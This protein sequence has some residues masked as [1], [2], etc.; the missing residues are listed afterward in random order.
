M[1]QKHTK[2]LLTPF[3]LGGITLPNRIIM[4]SMTRA[5]ATNTAI[6]PTDLHVAYY[7]QRASAGLIL[8]ESVWVSKNAIGFLNIPGIF[9]SAQTE[10]WKKVTDA[11]HQEN[12]RIFI[13]LAHIGAASHPDYFDGELPLGPSA[14]NPGEKSFTPQGFKD[15]VTPRAYTIEQIQE[16]IEE[17]HRAAINAKAAGFDGLELHAQLFTLIPQFLSAATNQRTDEYGGSITNR[18]RILFEI[19]DV[20]IKVFPGKKVGVKFTPA[21]FNT[22]VIKP[23]ENTIADYE[24]LLHKLNEYDIAFLEIVGPAVPLTCTPVASWGDQYYS[25]FRNNYKGTIMA[26]LGFTYNSGNKIVADGLADLVS[27]ATPFI[28]NPDLVNRFEHFL[29]LAVADQ[30]TY[31]T[32]GEKGF[33]DYPKTANL[34]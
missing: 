22:G 7:T 19:L 25:F 24:Y 27:F 17:Y 20:L 33:T 8:S 10:A 1:I 3:Q 9:T 34:K 13:Q 2:N 31:Y 32:G 28:A 23:D 29:P 16:T 15:T 18:S 6:I 4:A 12:G 11:V 21:A 14:I 30:A 5:R 26:N